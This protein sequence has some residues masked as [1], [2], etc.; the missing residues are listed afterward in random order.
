MKGV[1][2]DL[3][4]SRLSGLRHRIGERPFELHERVPIDFRIAAGHNLASH[5]PAPIDYISDADQDLLRI[6]AAQRTRAAERTRVDDG[7]V[8]ARGPAFVGHGGAG[9]AGSD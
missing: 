3:V 8:P 1:D 6:A 5:P 9:G 4:I 7:Y 2:A